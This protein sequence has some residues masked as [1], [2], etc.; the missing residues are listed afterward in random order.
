MG[1]GKSSVYT[2]ARLLPATAATHETAQVN[3]AIFFIFL[4]FFQKWS[5]VDGPQQRS[6]YKYTLTP[7]PVL[8]TENHPN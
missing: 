3:M 7:L 8:S 6:A 4:S 2:C 5:S 1:S